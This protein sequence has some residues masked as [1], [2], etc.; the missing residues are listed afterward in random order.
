MPA[1]SF[2][3]Q[4]NQ[5]IRTTGRSV[6]VSAAAGSGKTAVLAERCAHLV[7]DAPPD[8][9]CNVDELLVLTF[10]DAAAAEMRSRIVE[11]IRSRL[12][13]RPNDAR[14]A[15]QVA[16]ADSARISTIHS[17]CL[18]LV[19]RW[20]SHVGTDPAATVLDGD[21][22]AL[23]KSEVLD[24]L[25]RDLYDAGAEPGSPLGEIGTKT[26]GAP[27]GSLDQADGPGDSI[28]AHTHLSRAALGQAFVKLVD[29]Y[30]LG[31]DRSITRFV[32]K[33]YEFT[34]SLPDPEK[35][36][37]EAHESLRDRP[38]AT[39]LALAEELET[40]LWRQFEHCEQTAAMLGAAHPIG[41]FYAGQIRRYAGQLR[42]LHEI[43]VGADGLPTSDALEAF[44]TVRRRI[45][46]FEF[47]KTRAPNLPK[48]CDPAIREARDAAS[49]QLSHVKE[50]LFR[51]RLKKRFGLFSVDEWIAGVKKTAPYV[52]AMVS[53]IPAFREAYARRKRELNVLDFA[54]LERLAF[55]L[56]RERGEPSGPSEVALT[57]QRRFAY[58]LVDEFQDI[59]PLQQA[60]LELVSR[61]SDPQRVNNLFVVGDVKQSIY[62]F[63]LAEPSLF[64]ARL[65]RFRG[66]AD[67]G[68]AL[69]LQSNFRSRPE[70]LEAVNLVFRQLAREGCGG[71][72]YDS[73]AE[74]RLG[75][76]IDP[77]HPPQPVE[78]HLLE[79]RWTDENQ[80]NDAPEASPSKLPDP[81][82]WEAIERE[83]YLIGSC[84]RN[85]RESGRII[86]PGKPLC[87]R[88]VVVLLRA[89]R[90][91]AER[92]AVILAAMGIPAYA[93]VGG[94]LFAAREVRDVLAVLEVLDN[95]QQDIPL[96]AVLRGGVL[97]EPLSEDD[98]VEIRCLDR[99]IPF[100]A[101]VR[102]Y[103]QRG[104]QSDL[105]DRLSSLLGRIERYCTQACRRPLADVLAGL[106]EQNGY[107][108]YAGGLP[109]GA[110]RRANLLK[111]HELA[112]QFG[113]FRRQGLHRFLRF[114]QS[115]QEQEQHLATAPAIGEADDVV[116]IMTIHQAKGLEFPVVFV[117]GLGNM[118]NLGDRSGRMIFERTAKIGLRVVDTERM[119]EY[120]SAVHALVASEVERTA[121]EE[122]MRILYVAMT[123][124]RDKL[125]LIGSRPGI[126]P[127][128]AGETRDSNG[129]E[130]RSETT[131]GAPSTLSVA[132]ARTPLDWLIPAL[133]GAPPGVV[134]GMGARGSVNPIFD[135]HVHTADEM[136][137]WS[138]AGQVDDHER[139]ARRAVA[140]CDALPAD[141]PLSPAD[142]AVEEVVSRL[143]YV[144]PQLAASSVRASI[145]ASEFKGAYDFTRNPEQRT[146]Q[147]ASNEFVIPPSKYSTVAP[148][149]AAQ[150][151]LV[152]HR[153]LQHLDFATAMDAAGVASELHRM[154]AAG[155]IGEKELALVDRTALEWFVSTP[156]AQ[157]IREAGGAYRREFPYIAREPLTFF[158]RSVVPACDD[159]VLVRGIVDG[160][161]PVADAIGIVDFKTD[162]V[163]REEVEGRSKHYRPQME[164]YA[165]AV[166]RL[167]RRPVRTCWLVFLS[168]MTLVKWDD[169]APSHS[170]C[171]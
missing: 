138:V 112:R 74:L 157:A 89:A 46:E 170:D 94:S 80:E 49:K 57:L 82:Q 133:A 43:L 166:S 162:A 51:D 28:D 121:R 151:G 22:A 116:R 163:P 21:E 36:L 137:G 168:A 12:D 1:I 17:F 81:A 99:D 7:C 135:V 134:R 122:E 39:V 140:R 148:A 73:E 141:E 71:M 23:L 165:R 153:V 131:C 108:A 124:A 32:L 144:Y 38:E 13:A 45:A 90:F 160:I 127:Y 86:A 95:M 65:N 5:A 102:L 109:N 106:Y 62:R 60:I 110:Q 69:A 83:A 42:Q 155:M 26:R 20:F 169:L 152:V 76:Q 41:H 6:I 56:L 150:R 50:A 18:W 154:A 92:V 24:A 142:P 120:P 119:I 93:D 130:T 67:G 53:L 100:H 58:V 113:S 25:F 35:W 118:F 115:L 146:D 107:L 171:L 97:G 55:D 27:S 156:L 30:G 117:A 139:A 68:A 66:G 96:A 48:E 132:T 101:A 72:V 37:R 88:D 147:K 111:L 103:A 143:E 4:Q 91:N 33:L 129:G 104:E 3:P 19:R 40:E 52:A 75:R 47:D 87:Y 105:R 15:E 164:L 70:I 8:V 161:L 145:A 158:D 16:L 77:T 128:D 11:A 126:Q 14:L 2:T 79:R 125:V 136:S 85:W 44:E 78:V 31:E 10:T 63:R 34:T 59:N 114:I 123:R 64:T 98:L 9:R 61:E 54:D 29:D 159:Y 167:W 84:I 149:S